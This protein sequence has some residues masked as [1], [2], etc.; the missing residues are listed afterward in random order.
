M[1]HIIKN[2]I[3]HIIKHIIRHIMAAATGHRRGAQG[4][5]RGGR[6]P[7]APALVAVETERLPCPHPRPWPM[8]A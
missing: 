6:T 4:K 3:K 2:I 1:T 5:R 7:T 8:A